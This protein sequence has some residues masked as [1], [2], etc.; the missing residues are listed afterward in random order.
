MLTRSRLVVIPVALLLFGAACET[1]DLPSAA[2][3]PASDWYAYGGDSGGSRY[4]S[5]TQIDR[6]NVDDLEVAWTYRTGD[7]SH[8]DGSE[9]EATG[10][11]A[12]HQGDSK[13]QTTPILADGRLYVSTPFNRAIALDPERGEELWRY[14]PEIDI[15]INRNEGFI[16][17]GVSYWQEPGAAAG[18]CAKRVILPTVDARLISLD[19]TDGTLCP[20]FGDAGTVHLDL[21]VGEVRE[22]NYGVTSPPAIIGDLVIVGSSIGDNWRVRIAHGTVRAYDVRTG[23]LRWSW[24]P[25][26]RSADDPAW[27]TWPSET[28]AVQGT[29]NAW[30]P[31]SADPERDLVFVPTGAATPDF[32]GGARHGANEY[33]NS[34]VALRASTGEVVWHYQVIHHDMWDFDVP[35]QPTLITIPRDGR[36][37][38]AVAVGTKMG[39]VFILDRETGEPLFPVEERSVPPGAV[40]G[41]A[42]WPTQPVP[43]KPPPLHPTSLS[44]DDLFGVTPEDLEACRATVAGFRFGEIFTPPSVEGTVMYPGYGGG[45]NWGGLSWDPERNLLVTNLLRLGMWVRLLPREG[46]ELPGSPDALPYGMSRAVLIAPSGVPCSPPP[47]GTLVGIDLTD[48]DVSWEVPLGQ[49]PGLAEVPGSEEWGSPNL[50]GS[51]ITAGG[52]VFIGAA[53]DDAIRAFDVETGNLLWKHDLPAGGN[54]TPMTFEMNGRQYVVIA[55]GGHSSLG[56]TPGDHV[57]AFALP[58]S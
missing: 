44:P 37:I 7:W 43:L 36:D 42:A 41:E 17:R 23:E 2:S 21:G 45:I 22:G 8:E 31:L 46:I 48:G 5:L 16:S 14:D 40:P 6:T 3:P 58:D 54:A 49:V 57:V 56:S 39:F 35:A 9:G 50:G 51:A 11:A 25:I 10:C 27:D 28:A 33:T 47:W 26:P 12:C 13:F 1:T 53:M 19:A 32:Y 15:E 20:D 38:P 24:D 30:A 18:P 55:A 52:L 34:V 29:G 4:S